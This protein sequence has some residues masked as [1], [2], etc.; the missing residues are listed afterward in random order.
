MRK[1]VLK[2]RLSNI[3]EVDVL[4]EDATPQRDFAQTLSRKPGFYPL[5]TW[6]SSEMT[7]VSDQQTADESSENKKKQRCKPYLNLDIVSDEEILDIAEI[8]FQTTC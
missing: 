6:L 1:N 8:K 7:T 5:E 3:K 4:L 2:K